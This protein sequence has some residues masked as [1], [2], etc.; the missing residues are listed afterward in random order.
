LCNKIPTILLTSNYDTSTSH[1]HLYLSH[2]IDIVVTIPIIQSY[3]KVSPITPLPIPVP[4]PSPF[5]STHIS[6][7]PKLL[8]S[9]HPNTRL[10]ET[11][12]HGATHSFASGT[13]TRGPWWHP[14]GRSL[15]STASTSQLCDPEGHPPWRRAYFHLL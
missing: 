6:M 9:I 2:W 3:P 10:Y 13:V 8:S 5:F 1:H 15:L 7:N 14:S 11:L 4:S 12:I